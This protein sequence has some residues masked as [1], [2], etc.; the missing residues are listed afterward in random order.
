MRRVASQQ[1]CH[2]TAASA[3]GCKLPSAACGHGTPPRVINPHQ[4][5]SYPPSTVSATV[6]RDT[7]TRFPYHVA[8]AST[9]GYSS[10]ATPHARVLSLSLSLPLLALIPG[11]SFA[12]VDPSTIRA[13]PHNLALPPPPHGITPDVP[14]FGI[15]AALQS[16]RRRV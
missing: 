3:V 9:N 2:E 8:N 16:I 10:R 1:K 12:R 15:A 13:P 4:H 11:R 6:V 7:P 5:P 14:R